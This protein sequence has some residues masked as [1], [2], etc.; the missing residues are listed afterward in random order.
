MAFCHFW[1]MVPPQLRG[2][3]LAQ[4]G[5]MRDYMAAWIE[6]QGR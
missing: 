4:Y 2:L 1:G 6:A 5:A 3:T